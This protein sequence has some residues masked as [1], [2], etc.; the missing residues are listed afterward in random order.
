MLR[1]RRLLKG[2]ATL[3]LLLPA[4]LSRAAAATATTPGGGFHMVNGWI[5]TDRDVVALAALHPDVI[6]GSQA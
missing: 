2:L 6:P 4:G 5:L 1:R 3:L